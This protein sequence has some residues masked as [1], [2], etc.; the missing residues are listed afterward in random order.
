MKTVGIILLIIGIIASLIF[1]IQAISESETFSFLGIN[2]AVSSARWTP[3]I[4]SLVILVVG[5]IMT[6]AAKRSRI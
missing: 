4:I 2:V 1:G 3:V 6:S 5:V